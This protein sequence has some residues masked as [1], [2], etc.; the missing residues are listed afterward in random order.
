MIRIRTT[1]NIQKYT[2]GTLIGPIWTKLVA[3]PKTGGKGF[4]KPPN[5]ALMTESHKIHSIRVATTNSSL[6]PPWRVIGS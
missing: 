2:E 3:S 6:S 1:R 5:V 4:G